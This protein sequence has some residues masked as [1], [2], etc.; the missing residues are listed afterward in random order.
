[1]SAEEY[2]FI[3]VKCVGKLCIITFNDAKHLNYF[4]QSRYKEVTKALT[5]ADA[6]NSI[7]AIAITGAGKIFSCGNDF[8]ALTDKASILNEISTIVLR[9]FFYAFLDC[10]KL[11]IAVVNG[12]A[13]GVGATLC[14]LCDIVYASNT[15]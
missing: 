6:N 14:G 5:D 10:S 3:T 11:L 1:M 15:V 9:E 7:S 2:K 13:I 4:N 8:K 12:P